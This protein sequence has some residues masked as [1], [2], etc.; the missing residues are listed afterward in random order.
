M[1]LADEDVLPGKRLNSLYRTFGHRSNSK[2]YL[3]LFGHWHLL[4]N[5][6]ASYDQ[7]QVLLNRLEI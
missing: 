2:H 3:K 4:I 5:I 1:T 6:S 7:C